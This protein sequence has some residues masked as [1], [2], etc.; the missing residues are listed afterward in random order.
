MYRLTVDKPACKMTM[1]ELAHNACYLK[2]GWARYR[3]YKVDTDTRELTRGLLKQYAYGDDAFTCDNDFA[4]YMID[5][6]QLGLNDIE[7]LIAVFH[8]N[9]WAMADLRERLKEYEDMEEQGRLLKLPCKFGDTVFVKM[10]YGG[11]AQAEVR[12]FI[13]S[14]SYGFCVVVTSDKFDKQNIPFSEFGK[15]IFLAC[16]DSEN[17]N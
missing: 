12:D 11:Y 10:Q 15:T 13:Y 9:M 7:G 14:I 1:V 16:P 17:V 2:D 8:R 3:D 5:T 4:D 6:L